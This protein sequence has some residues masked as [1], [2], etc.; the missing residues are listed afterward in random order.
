MRINPAALAALRERSGMSQAELA[1]RCGV[2]QSH[3]SAIERDPRRSNVRPE[4]A[5]ALAR[6][7]KVSLVA[8]L[9]EPEPDDEAVE[10]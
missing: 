6:G 5:K 9:A 2:D 8:I 1:R 10:A 3:L 4:T 7:L